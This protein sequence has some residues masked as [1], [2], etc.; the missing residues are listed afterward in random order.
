[1]SDATVKDGTMCPNKTV[2]NPGIIMSQ[3]CVDLTF[4][5]SGKLM[6]SGLVA[7]RLLT[8]STPSIIKMDVAP[9]SAIAQFHPIVTELITVVNGDNVAAH[10]GSHVGGVTTDT[11]DAATV[12]LSAISKLCL[13]GS[14]V[15]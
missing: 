3:T 5:P 14:E 11:L 9:V 10:I 7:M 4:F 8:T 13:V 6:M 15:F 1:M 2:G 12:S